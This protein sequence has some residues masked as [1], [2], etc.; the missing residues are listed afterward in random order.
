MTKEEL[1]R[2][3]EFLSAFHV[4][5]DGE[6]I[7]LTDCGN[8]IICNPNTEWKEFLGHSINGVADAVARELGKKTKY[9]T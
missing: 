5:I 6:Y 3:K 2:C 8:S 7:E 9:I 4:D 1:E